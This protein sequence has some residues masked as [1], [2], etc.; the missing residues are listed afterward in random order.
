M[1]LVK[2]TND[3]YHVN[4]PTENKS[5]YASSHQNKIMSIAYSCRYNVYTIFVNKSPEGELHLHKESYKDL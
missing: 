5:S 3:F 2:T 1:L 4:G